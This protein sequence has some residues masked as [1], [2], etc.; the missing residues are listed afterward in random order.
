M[1]GGVRLQS[2]DCPVPA[3]VGDALLRVDLV[4]LFRVP[5]GFRCGQLSHGAWNLDLNLK[6]ALPVEPVQSA[7][8]RGWVLVASRT[9]VLNSRLEPG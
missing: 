7:L 3:V 5:A 6:K 9:G 4:E 1:P 2:D 8:C